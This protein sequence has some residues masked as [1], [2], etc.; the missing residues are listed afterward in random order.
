LLQRLNVPGRG[1]RSGRFATQAGETASATRRTHEA[2]DVASAAALPGGAVLE[3]LASG[4]GGL[5]PDEAAARLRAFGPNALSVRRVSAAA[6]LLR[7]LGN[8]CFCCCSRRPPFP[9]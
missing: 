6:I 8:P 9:L 2:L 3:R 7:Q 4:D 5:A 1:S